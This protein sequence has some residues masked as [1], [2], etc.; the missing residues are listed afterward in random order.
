MV[1]WFLKGVPVAPEY[2]DTSSE[3]SQSATNP[4]RENGGAPYGPQRAYGRNLLMR[5]FT[6]S[7]ISARGLVHRIAGPFAID[8]WHSRQFR[9]WYVRIASSERNHPGPLGA[10]SRRLLR[11]RPNLRTCENT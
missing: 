6:R 4:E 5:P 7:K 9:I 1:V 10:K 8:R 3:S 2:Q 11:S